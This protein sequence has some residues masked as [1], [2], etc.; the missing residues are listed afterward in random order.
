MAQFCVKY[1][2]KSQI[3]FEIFGIVIKECGKLTILGYEF[4]IDIGDVCCRKPSYGPYESRIILNKI[5]QLLNNELVKSCEGPWGSMIDL[6]QKPH[7]ESVVDIE[8][9]FMVPECC[10][11]NVSISNTTVP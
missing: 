6:A 1:K 10:D 4:G 2:I 7:Q 9:F 5:A 11:Y 8:G 3:S